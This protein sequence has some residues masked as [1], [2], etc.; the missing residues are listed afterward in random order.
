MP[1]VIEVDP[2]T[3]LPFDQPTGVDQTG[4]DATVYGIETSLQF[5][6]SEYWSVNL[7]G[8][9]TD[10]EFDDANLATYTR[11][12]SFW[13]DTNG[14]GFG[15]QGDISGKKVLRQSEWQGNFTAD[16]RRP[17]YQ[18]WDWYTRGDVLHQ[19]SQWVGSANQAK[20][21]GRTV[22]NLRL[23]LD[24]ERYQVEFWVENLFDDDKPTATFRDVFFANTHNDVPE[25]K[26]FGDLFPFRMT[27]R[28]PNRRTFGLTGRVRF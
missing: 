25:V 23:G 2:V 3:G 26:G 16:Y 5:L 8:S 28:Y 6:L 14:D 24:S 21:P 20:I 15:D 19:S 22:V 13:E 4:G 27:V 12:P 9:W 18:D 17:V 10:A 11:F 1:Q 7:G